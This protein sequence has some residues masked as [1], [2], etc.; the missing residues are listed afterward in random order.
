MKIGIG[1]LMQP[2]PLSPKTLKM[3][4]IPLTSNGQNLILGA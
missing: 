2:A 3:N 1:I 4:N